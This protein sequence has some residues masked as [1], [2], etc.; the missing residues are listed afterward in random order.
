[1]I[2]AGMDFGAK[3]VKVV[4]LENGRI[5]GKAMLQASRD[6]GATASLVYNKAL[7]AAGILKKDVNRVFV[8]GTGRKKCSFADSEIDEVIADARGIVSVAP[9]VRTFIDV[10][11]EG[12]RAVRVNDKGEVV[13]YAVNDKCAAGAGIFV[14]TVARALET[15]VE[16]MSE[17]YEQSRREIGMNA[18]CMVFAE[19]ELVWFLHANTAMP[20]IVRAV[21]TAI[22]DMIVSIV[23]RVGVENDLA[24]T[25]GMALNRGFVKA[26]EKEMNV[27]IVVP[28]DPQFIG[29][30]GAAI[31]AAD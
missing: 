28:A 22:A 6:D 13:D 9:K 4:I 31:A 19:S 30:L 16:N 27:K 24:A 26:I 25:G 7:D 12:G 15:E 21:L 20:D 18:Q 14:D 10:G 17:L 5:V 3:N 2:T 11:A 23:R 8:T 29:A 1:M